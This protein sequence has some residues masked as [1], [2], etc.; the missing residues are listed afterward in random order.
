MKKYYWR[1]DNLWSC[2]N[3]IYFLRSY[4]GQPCFLQVNL[5]YFCFYHSYWLFYQ[6][7]KVQ[8]SNKI[9]VIKA[10]KLIKF[11][12]KAQFKTAKKDYFTNY[13]SYPLFYGQFSSNFIVHF[14][15]LIICTN[16]FLLI[17][18]LIIEKQPFF[19]FLI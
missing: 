15:Y 8:T 13:L 19:D 2:W 5:F 10:G 17:F 16:V 14:Y 6:L 3:C 18:N 9:Y 7:T 11:L 12:M 1:S 4:M